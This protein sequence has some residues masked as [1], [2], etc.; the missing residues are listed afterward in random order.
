V[1]LPESPQHRR[2]RHSRTL[3]GERIDGFRQALRESLAE[4]GA[5]FDT[6]APSTA[7]VEFAKRLGHDCKRLGSATYCLLE[8]PEPADERADMDD[9]IKGRRNVWD[10]DS[11][12]H[13]Y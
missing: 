5:L 13:S 6:E 8:W 4:A 3:A 1:V 10:W 12:H 11:E 2:W 7:W 9:E